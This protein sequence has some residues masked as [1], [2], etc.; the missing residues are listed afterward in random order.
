MERTDPTQGAKLVAEW[1]SLIEES[2]RRLEGFHAILT[3]GALETKMDEQLNTFIESQ[4]AADGRRRDAITQLA[5]HADQLSEE[6]RNE[7]I[8]LHQ[9]SEDLS[10]RSVALMDA[11]LKATAEPT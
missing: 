2:E 8:E 3:S 4:A 9:R 10:R 5:A 11:V 6:E 7:M 1:R